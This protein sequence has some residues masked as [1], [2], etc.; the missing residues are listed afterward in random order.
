MLL[1]VAF[2]SGIL[3]DNRV[4]FNLKVYVLTFF[5]YIISINSWTNAKNYCIIN[6]SI[7]SINHRDQ[8]SPTQ[9][10]SKTPA[11]PEWRW[12]HFKSKAVKQKS[13]NYTKVNIF[14][15]LKIFLAPKVAPLSENENFVKIVKFSGAYIKCQSIRSE[16]WIVKME[17]GRKFCAQQICKPFVRLRC[18]FSAELLMN[19]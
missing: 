16:L 2:Y 8:S 15:T 5:G 12:K 11:K 3:V 17:T 18:C 9:K 4:G 10:L 14:V 1:C 13:Y 19:N 6:Y 7:I